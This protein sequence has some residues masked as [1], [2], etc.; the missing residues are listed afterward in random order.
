MTRRLL[1]T[2]AATVL[3]VAALCLP[4]VADPPL[5]TLKVA[6]TPIDIGAQALWAKDQ[7][8]FKKAGLDVEVSLISNGAAIASAVAA[9]AVDI[10]QANIVSLATA[11][12]RGLPFV[13][14]APAGYYAA[15]EPTTAMIVAKNSPFRFA[16]DLNGKT[17]AVSGIKNIT[18]VGASAWLSQNGGDY[19]SVHFIE[20]PF[21]QMAPA[22]AAGRVDAA[23][24][25]E[26]ELSQTLDGNGRLMGN[27]Y[28]GVAKEFVLGAWF[29]TSDWAKGHPDVV[30]R[31]QA[32]MVET[33][34]WANAHHAESAKILEKYTKQTVQPHMRRVRFATKF[35]ASEVQPLI[36]ASAKYGVIK[37]SFP[38]ADLIA[39]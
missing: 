17:I 4:T 7:G 24:I 3:L 6:T 25:A 11:H 22:L 8:F 28:D 1:G 14:I 32:A 18:Q 23:V 5:V 37:A 16:K 19:G 15:T 13:V 20:L 35:T 10:G 26:P 2:V 33:A 12:E 34:N 9:N 36:D 27:V 21:P 30:K 29:T 38:A 39:Q 31:F